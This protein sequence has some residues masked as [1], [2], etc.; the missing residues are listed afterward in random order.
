MEI[1]K[2]DYKT[3]AIATVGVVGAAVIGKV[4]YSCVTDPS[5]SI[6]SAAECDCGEEHGFI[7]ELMESATALSNKLFGVKENKVEISIVDMAPSEVV[8][9]PAVIMPEVAPATLEVA[10]KKS[11]LK[12][13]AN[14][15]AAI[16]LLPVVLV[17]TAVK[18]LFN[19]FASLFGRGSS[20]KAAAL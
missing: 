13:C 11:V 10:S 20:S 8:E 5:S 16:A 18:G 4:V 17:V 2:V 14:L 1:P 3:A 19:L 9:A 7:H 6:S 12:S 15:V